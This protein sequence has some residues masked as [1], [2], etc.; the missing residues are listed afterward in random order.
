[1][2]YYKPR[3]FGNWFFHS[4]FVVGRVSPRLG[5]C[6]GTVDIG[7]VSVY[8]WPTR[9][10]ELCYFLRYFILSN[11]M[12]CL[13]TRVFLLSCV[14]CHQKPILCKIPLNVVSPPLKPIPELFISKSSFLIVTQPLCTI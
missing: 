9:L 1:M 4:N 5:V 2:N 10:T 6:M 3:A 11:L 13:S 8:D 7:F 14:F 12:S